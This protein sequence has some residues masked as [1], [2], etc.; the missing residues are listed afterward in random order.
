MVSSV[1]K[2]DYSHTTD[3]G[4]I[5]NPDAARFYLIRSADVFFLEVPSA[6]L[7]FLRF[8]IPSKGLIAFS[9]QNLVNK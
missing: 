2:A 3:K 9:L 1:L 7:T 4:T 5:P 8:F 6:Y